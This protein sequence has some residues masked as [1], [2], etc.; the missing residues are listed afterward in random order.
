MQYHR[1]AKTNGNQ[2][3]AIKEGIESARVPGKT[4]KISNVAAAK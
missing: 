1:N 2:Q 3:E 4:C